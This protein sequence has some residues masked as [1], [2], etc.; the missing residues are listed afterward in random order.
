VTTIARLLRVPDLPF[1]PENLRGRAFVVVEAAADEER[2]AAPLLRALRSLRPEI[3][4][5]APL[6]AAELATVHGDPPS[7]VPGVGTGILLHALPASAL[8]AMIASAGAGSRSALLSLEVRQ[9]GGAVAEPE[10]VDAVLGSIAEPYAV[11][12]VGLAAGPELR[13]ATEA[14]LDAAVTALA[15]WRSERTLPT[16]ADA[17]I[18]P[19]AVFGQERAARLLDVER[20]V[21]PEG[22]IVRNRIGG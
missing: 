6:P 1:L 12:G 11:F 14:S 16:L 5:F 3:D 10:P 2:S 7:P 19:V 20:A 8:E 13:A 9:L 15:P 21:D 17:P 18:D 4:T 22:R